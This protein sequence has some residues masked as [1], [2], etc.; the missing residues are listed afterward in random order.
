[1]W[2]YRSF[3]AHKG[4]RLFYFLE[5]CLWNANYY[6]KSLKLN[7]KLKKPYILI[8]VSEKWFIGIILT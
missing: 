6:V 5:N 1:M 4:F 3:Y 8:N 7:Y 2:V